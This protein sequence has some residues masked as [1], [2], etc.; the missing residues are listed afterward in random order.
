MSSRRTSSVPKEDVVSPRLLYCDFRCSQ[1]CHWRLQVL[2]GLSSALPVLLL[3]LPGAPRCNWWPLR[4][5]S[6]LWDV[7]TLGLWSDN[8]Q[9][10]P[11]AP[12]DIISFCWWL[13]VVTSWIWP[14]RLR[15]GSRLRSSCLMMLISP[16][17]LM[18][19]NHGSPKWKCL[20]LCTNN[21]SSPPIAWG[22]SLQHPS[23]SNLSLSRL[24]CW[25]LRLFIFHC[26]SMAVEGRPQSCFLKMI[27]EVHFAHRLW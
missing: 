26:L 15:F 6:Q 23:I 20:I 19:R 14:L 18:I 5:S 12:S 22:A 10:L 27:I 11:E 13:S 9:T 17:L 1:A 16:W 3:A 21:F 25:Q 7:T 4:R 8:S 2:P 24:H